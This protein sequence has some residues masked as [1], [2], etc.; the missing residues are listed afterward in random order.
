MSTCMRDVF[1]RIE[2]LLDF[3]ESTRGSL[4]KLELLDVVDQT[5]EAS[6][7]SFGTIRRLV[8]LWNML[9]TLDVVDILESFEQGRG[10]SIWKFDKER[11]VAAE[12]LI[13]IKPKTQN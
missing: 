12:D 4:K 13:Q 11:E 7:G 5:L 6:L 8:A 3:F 10:G 1:V 9:A 2:E